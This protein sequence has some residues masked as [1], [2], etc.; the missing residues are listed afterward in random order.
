MNSYSA[1]LEDEGS[2]ERK[3]MS[4]RVIANKC[5]SGMCPTVY[6]TDVGSLV[7]QGYAV[8]AELSGIDLP[9]GEQLVEIP[10]ELLDEV[11]RNRVPAGRV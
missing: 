9:A 2:P 5:T 11:V 1:R 7:V 10:F 3:P 6:Q 4:L 8:S